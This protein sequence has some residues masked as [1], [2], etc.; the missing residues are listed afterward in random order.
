MT[1]VISYQFPPEAWG[2]PN[3]PETGIWEM[4][5]ETPL[6]EKVLS[7]ALMANRS[8]LDFVLFSLCLKL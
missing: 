5:A 1:P 4:G 3:I 2:V 8:V 7:T 6:L